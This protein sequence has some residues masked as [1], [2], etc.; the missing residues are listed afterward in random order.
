MATYAT[1]S[2]V[3]AV[4][5]DGST[6]AAVS[7]LHDDAYADINDFLRERLGDYTA[8]ATMVAKLAEANV[9]RVLKRAEVYHVLW[10]W[11]LGFPTDTIR[12]EAARAYAGL[13]NDELNKL[14]KADAELSGMLVSLGTGRLEI[15]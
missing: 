1:A 10:H 14:P 2:D 9:A 11:F 5:K 13:Y 4:I 6:W 12:M 7:A 8:D 3:Q 15:Q